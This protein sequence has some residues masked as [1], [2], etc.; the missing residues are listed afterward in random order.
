MKTFLIIGLPR[1]RTAWLSCLFTVGPAFCYHEMLAEYSTPAAIKA[2]MEVTPFE[3]V[4]DSDPSAALRLDEVHETL[5]F[6]QTIY[7]RREPK[8]CIASFARATGLPQGDCFAILT[9]LSDRL[10]TFARNNSTIFVLDFDKI[11][12]ADYIANAWAWVL[13]TT[14]FPIEHWHRMK[15]LNVSMTREALL[16]LVK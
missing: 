16:R 7:V 4:G 11:D 9:Q 2:Q 10:D 14:P 3:F 1:S 8:D 15:K 6:P 13:G 5:G 12:H